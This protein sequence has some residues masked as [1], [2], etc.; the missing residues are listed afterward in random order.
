M[1]E[2]HFEDR[3]FY[4]GL[5]AIGLL[6]MALLFSMVLMLL[7]R[8]LPILDHQGLSFFTTLE[9]NPVTEE[10]GA[11]AFAYGTV[12][13]SLLGLLIATPISVGVALFLTE[14]VRGPLSKII[15]FSIEMLAAIPS[16]VYG[17]WGILVWP[18]LSV[19]KFKS[20]SL[21]KLVIFSCFK[22]HHWAWGC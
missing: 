20:P 5:R 3:L 15:G 21:K 12:V 13:S 10:F 17:L 22:D 18:L 11:A 2:F 14:V 19:K 4:L 1:R 16:V 7:V 6:T 9:W 8:S